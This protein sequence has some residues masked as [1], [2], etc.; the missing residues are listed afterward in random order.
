MP[1]TIGH[2]SVQRL[3]ASGAI[4]LD[5]LP[6]DEF[7]NEHIAGAIH[8]PLR[9]LTRAA[10]AHLGKHDPVIVYCWDMQ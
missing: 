4:L 8:L 9:K 6:G 5:V 10:T 7:E 1:T 2:R 3:L